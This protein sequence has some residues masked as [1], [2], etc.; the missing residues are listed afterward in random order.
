M[1]KSF[2]EQDSL[3]IIN[4]MI[5]QAQNN[6]RK[7]AGSYSIFW[8]Y[9]IAGLAI[10]HLVLLHIFISNDVSPAYTS[11]VW[12]ITFPV[13]VIYFIYIKAQSKKKMM[14]VTHIDKIISN[15]WIAFA[16]SCFTFILILYL[17]SYTFGINNMGYLSCPVILLLLGLAQ[18]ASAAALRFK[19]YY[20]AAGIFWVGSILS[21]LVL[22]LF[23]RGDIQ[24]AIMAA[25][26]ILGLCLPGHLLNR[27]AEQN[28]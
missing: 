24:L 27:K 20:Y 5:A 23:N 12:F 4:E 9:F 10:L 26:M 2:T 7:G 14:V 18:A 22:M 8:G 25:C 13:A 6:Y 19:L 16:V 28:V 21:M 1:E 3:R 11:Y 17:Y 15:I